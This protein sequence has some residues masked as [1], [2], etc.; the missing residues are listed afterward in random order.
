MHQFVNPSEFLLLQIIS[1]RT[2]S[3]KNTSMINSGVERDSIKGS[4]F[5]S[6]VIFVNPDNP[7]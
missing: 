5:S 1:T 3:S 6:T 7:Q 2:Y 4:K